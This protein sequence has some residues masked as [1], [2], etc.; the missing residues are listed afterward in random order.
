[1]LVD[2]ERSYITAGFFRYTMTRRF[3][4]S[5]QQAT[6]Q[7]ALNKAKTK[8]SGFGSFLPGGGGGQNDAAGDHMDGPASSAL[9]TTRASGTG[10]PP[11]L[12][13]SSFADPQDYIAAYFGKK[14]NEEAAR[15]SLPVDAWRWQK[16][17]FILSGRS[18][19]GCRLLGL[20]RVD[21]TVTC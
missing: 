21:A 19:I 12:N 13:L 2:M 1:M 3:E 9:S 18:C 11:G 14:V 17:F 10:S 16:R 4:R 8:K 6:L 5:Q 20:S 15:H 7:Q